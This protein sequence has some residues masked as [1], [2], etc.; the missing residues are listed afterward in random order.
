MNFEVPDMYRWLTSEAAADSIQS[1][2]SDFE[3]RV[4]PLK[5]ARQ[6]RQNISPDQSALVMEQA[7]LQ[8]R[9]RGK[10]SNAD[11]MFF[12]GRSLQQSTSE[13]IARYK[14]TRFAGRR[15]VADV[16]CG[17]GGD[18]ISLARRSGADSPIET[19]GI[20]NDPVPAWLA[21]INVKRA[22][23]PNT[24][25][26][27]QT[28]ESSD[29]SRFDGLHFDPDRR[30]RGRTISTTACSP[31]LPAIVDSV[32]P[33][34]QLVAIKLAPATE[35][36]LAETGG[37]RE[38]IG[39]RHECKQQVLW[40]GDDDTP[41]AGDTAT[42]LLNDGAVHT[43]SAS[44]D[45][46]PTAVAKKL[47]GFIYEPHNA[48][49]A[50]RLVDAIADEHGLTR[51]AAR[52]A[53]LHGERRIDDLFPLMSG[54]RID[55]V[56]T[57]DNRIVTKALRQRGVGN[58]ILKHRSIRKDEA[59]RFAKLKLDGDE[60]ATLILTRFAGGRAALIVTPLVDLI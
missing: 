23:L 27:C 51:L 48:V 1:A 45:Y 53:Y 38:W 12:T 43:F 13:T 24:S 59:Q 14:A 35:I 7:Q 8:L 9:A 29:T 10:F 56:M 32:R 46:E 15:A 36:E 39:D 42:I 11:A 2:K 31:P 26:L 47:S 58:V 25:V 6:L 34:Q 28:F 5:I 57:M 3:N 19:V 52:T 21:T 40:I 17:I 50:A 49:I 55:A 54:Y 16:C 37:R 30:M 18:L 4:S 20:D 22:S 33:S 41:D 60:T 44:P